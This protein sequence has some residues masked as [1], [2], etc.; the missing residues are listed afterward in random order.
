M[1]KTRKEME[2]CY[3]FDGIHLSNEITTDLLNLKEARMQGTKYIESELKN[4]FNKDYTKEEQ[5]EDKIR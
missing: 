1:L 5:E 2:E 4:D 3:E